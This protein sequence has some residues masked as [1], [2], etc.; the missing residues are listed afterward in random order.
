MRSIVGTVLG[1]LALL[2]AATSSAGAET[3]TVASTSDGKGACVGPVCPTLRAAISAA[4]LNPGADEI[5]LQAGTFRIELGSATTEDNNASGDLDVTDDLTING[6]GANATTILGALPAGQGE[7]DIHVPGKANLTL[8]GLTVSGGRGSENEAFSLGGGIYS[9]GPGTLTLERVVVSNN[10]AVGGKASF[11]DGGGIAKTA[12]RLVV[13]DS[14]IVDNK[15][16]PPGYGGAVYFEGEH[17][18]ADLTNVTIAANSVSQQGGGLESNAIGPLMLA[19]VTVMGNEAGV[20]GGGIGNAEGMQMRNTIIDGNATPVLPEHV[21]PIGA[22]CFEGPVSEGGNVADPACGLSH[23]SDAPVFDPVVGPLEGSPIPVLEPL[24]G[25]PALDRAV[26]PCPS[27][28]ARGVPRPQGAACDSGAAERPVPPGPGPSPGTG[29]GPSGTGQPADV[30]APKLVL[31]SSLPIDAR[32]THVRVRLTCP[33]AETSCTGRIT[34]VGRTG[35]ARAAGKKSKGT[36]PV[37]IAVGRFTLAGGRTASISV[38]VTRAG[39]K[40]LRGHRTL[41]ASLAVAVADAAGNRATTSRTVKLV[42]AR[43]ATKPGGR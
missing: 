17:T 12:G 4:N 9:P 1:T 27:T 43:S 7:R 19:F 22:N 3:F 39:R 6:A 8:T 20:Q 25:S 18:T 15:A 37:T 16:E 38:A 14:A 23:V 26:G 29:A 33:A 36:R 40:L 41:R 2:W 21:T 10:V 5:D 24:P 35:K 34:I 11:A 32:L 28:D 42:I 30:T 31:P 13:H